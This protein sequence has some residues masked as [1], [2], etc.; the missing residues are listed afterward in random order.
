MDFL[1]KNEYFFRCSAVLG[2]NT[3]GVEGR[4]FILGLLHFR[5]G[6]EE[7]QSGFSSLILIHAI[8]MKPVPASAAV[9]I[10]KQNAQIVP[11]KEPIKRMARL[12]EPEGVGSGP[13]GLET[14]L[15]RRMSFDGLLVKVCPRSVAL[16]KSV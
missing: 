1:W 7:C 11:S 14:C 2:E 3:G 10:V 4:H 6:E 12:S 9:R 5:K 13:V 16:K 15:Q 8:D